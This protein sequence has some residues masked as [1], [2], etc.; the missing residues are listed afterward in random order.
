MLDS[1]KG[2]NM[3]GQGGKDLNRDMSYHEYDGY[4][5]KNDYERMGTLLSQIAPAFHQQEDEV[6]SSPFLR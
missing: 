6:S 2:A 3:I 1:R 5:G 4:F